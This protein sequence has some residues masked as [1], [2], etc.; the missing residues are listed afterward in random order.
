MEGF[1]VI[2]FTQQKRRYHRPPKGQRKSPTWV[3]TTSALTAGCDSG[4]FFVH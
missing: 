1:L 4:G 3:K 2:F